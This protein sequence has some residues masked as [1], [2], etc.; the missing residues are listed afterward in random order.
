MMVRLPFARG[1][2]GVTGRGGGGG[3]GAMPTAGVTSSS[4]VDDPAGSGD[5]GGGGGAAGE[6]RWTTVASTS[7]RSIHDGISPE[8]SAPDGRLVP[9]DKASVKSVM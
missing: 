1:G 6:G 9:S 4:P 8:P 7:T 5:G 3:D 2:G